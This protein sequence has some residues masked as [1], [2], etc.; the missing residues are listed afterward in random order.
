MLVT[1]VDNPND[2]KVVTEFAVDVGGGDRDDDDDDGENVDDNPD[3]DD[4]RVP[5]LVPLKT[6]E[7][8]DNDV[9]DTNAEVDVV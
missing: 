9:G 3:D 6:T 2:G 8:D 5:V 4:V 7:S 1:T